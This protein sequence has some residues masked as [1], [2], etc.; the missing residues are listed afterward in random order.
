MT[1]DFLKSIEYLN[2]SF[3]QIFKHNKFYNVNQYK[4]TYKY[5]MYTYFFFINIIVIYTQ[6]DLHRQALS[7]NIGQSRG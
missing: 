1:L 7:L 6:V 4:Y 5:I 3:I 2:I